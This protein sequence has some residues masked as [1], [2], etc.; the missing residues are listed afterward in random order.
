M[1]FNRRTILRGMLG[2]TAVSVALPFLEAQAESGAP[3]P[4]V[5]ISWFQSLGLNPGRWKPA[6]TGSA[7]E[8]NVELKVLDPF[9]RR[10]NVISGM[11]YFMDGR[12]LETHTSGNYIAT[13]GYLPMGGPG[14]ATIDTTIGETIGARTRFRSLE[15]SMGGGRQSWSKRAGGVTNPSDP[16][17]SSLYARLF[18]PDFKDPNAAEFVPETQAMARLSVLS[19]IGDERKAFIGRVGAADRAR[20]DEYF[21]AV[22]Q[23]EQQLDLSLQK[24]TPLP[25]CRVAEKVDDAG[26]SPNVTGVEANAKLF[27]Q[28]MAHAVA[29]DQTRI[30]NVNFNSMGMHRPGAVR[31]WHNLT[32][33]EPLDPK[34]GY[35]PETTWFIEF[36]MARFADFIRELDLYKE[37]SGSVLDRVLMIWQTDHGYART[38]SMDDI[39]VLTVGSGGGRINTGIHVSAPGEPTTRIG[40]TVQQALGVA[41]NS[42]GKMSN[43]TSRPFTELLA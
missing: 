35:Q 17:P 41:T 22:R 40:L 43:Q 30:L 38:H 29:C 21:T 42:W 16:S 12:P 33:E 6:K 32:H 28:L 19:A 1:S 10:V 4:P 3:L 18:G 25:A 39:P 36:G 27:S 11:K 23:I 9:K 14:G 5:F 2:G 24:P 13:M 15:V 37:G 20:I 34:L 26:P 8:N 31:E 7:Y